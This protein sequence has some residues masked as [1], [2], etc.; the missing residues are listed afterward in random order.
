MK[1]VRAVLATVLACGAHLPATAAAA[2]QAAPADVDRWRQ[3]MQSARWTGPMLASTAETLPRG[4]FY[5]EPYFYDVI[6]GGKHYPG[7]SGFYQ[8]GLSDN[9]TVGLQPTFALGLYHPNRG[10][11]FGDLTLLSQLRLTHFR[12]DHRVPSISIVVDEVLPTGK[13]DR[14]AAREAGHGSGVFATDIGVNV[15]NYFLLRNGRLLRG[16]INVLRSFPH[17][18]GLTGRSVYG[19]GPDFRGHADPGSK[20]TIIAAVEYSVTRQWVVAFDVIG[21]STTSTRVSGRDGNGGPVDRTI[22]ASRSI[23]FA[24]AIE[25][26]WSDRA[27]I[28]LG[29][30]V[31]PKGHNAA[32]SVTPAI[33]IQRFW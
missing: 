29:V 27:G 20:T 4:H 8:Y 33:A 26:N 5:T 18:A 25:Y 24:P 7:S 32:S 14:L 1:L 10:V 31:S 3:A 19:T 16:R 12:P 21:Q 2:P 6:S 13:Y 17:S 28:L 15:Q 23:G 9:L 30:W 11:A 22:P